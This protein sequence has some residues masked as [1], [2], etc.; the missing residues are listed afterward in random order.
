M[1]K[2]FLI[3]VLAFILSVPSL[4]LGEESFP[5]ES[6]GEVDFTVDAARFSLEGGG[7]YLEFYYEIPSE[8]LTYVEVEGQLKASFKAT[9]RLRSPG[10]KEVVDEWERV[11]YLPSLETAR[12][13]DL[14]ALDQYEICLLRPGEYDFS[15]EIHDLNSGREGKVSRKISSIRWKDELTLSDIQFATAVKQDTTQGPF[16]KRGLMVTPNPTHH[17]GNRRML[18]YSYSEIYNLKGE[19]YEVRYS[20]YDEKGSLVKTLPPR[21][22]PTTGATSLE[23]GAINVIA[24][25]AGDYHLRVEVEDGIGSAVSESSFKVAEL[26][27]PREKLALSEQVKEYYDL[28]EYVATQKELRFYRTLSDTGK[29]EYLIGF[30]KRMDPT[31]ATP[32]N[33]ALD[34]F[35]RRVRYADSEYG[36][37]FGKGRDTDR[38]RVFIKYGTPDEI[39]SHPAELTYKPYESWL[40]YGSGGKQFIFVDLSGYG[41]YELIYSSEGSELTDPDWEK[42]VDP[43]VVQVRKR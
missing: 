8:E 13:R 18:L 38:G 3:L 16:T 31:P 25:P 20:I 23:V 5:A 41:N 43:S 29:K 15:L 4:S 37:Q 40:Y 10:G 35:V 34:E 1:R 30:W 39:E 36:S 24:L 27:L 12:S 21:R 9:M 19:E 14:S 33:E 2:L 6:A 42:Y 32:E 17:F 7:T 22:F 26:L 11:S 28:I